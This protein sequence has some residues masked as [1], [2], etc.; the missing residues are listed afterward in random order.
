[1]PSHSQTATHQ[2]S[3]QQWHYLPLATPVVPTACD[4]STSIQLPCGED[5]GCSAIVQ[6]L[7][8]DDT[9]PGM[10]GMT[11]VQVHL[12]FS[13]SYDGVE[14][15]CALVEWFEKADCKL[16]TGMWVI[17]PDATLSNGSRG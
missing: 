15:P 16:V 17:H 10:L 5:V 9:S 7:L 12:F 6:L 1:M 2:Y 8:E 11:V 14:Y 4:M 13:F 3:I